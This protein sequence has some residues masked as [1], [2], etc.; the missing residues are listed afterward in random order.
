MK[1]LLAVASLA[2]AIIALPFPLGV[3]AQEAVPLPPGD[4]LSAP[5]P[6]DAVGLVTSLIPLL[7]PVLVAVVKVLVPRIPRPLLPWLTP[8]FGAAIEWLGHVAGLTS[9]NLLVGALVGAA[10][11]GV[12]EAWDQARKSAV[13]WDKAALFLV[14]LGAVAFLTPGCASYT[15][16]QTDISHE[17]ETASRAITT[18]VKVR[19]LFDSD[20]QLAK[21]KALQTDKTQSSETSGL[22]QTSSSEGLRQLLLQLAEA[23]GKGVS[24]A[25]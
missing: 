14:T 15:T 18:T 6:V 16:K 11:V 22:S 19:T 9:G 20:S 13:A 24:P 4:T 1:R 3:V 5:T 7:T 2:A 8:L 10:G 12:R 21:S 17:S 25:P 23:I